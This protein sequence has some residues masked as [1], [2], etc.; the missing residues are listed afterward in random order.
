MSEFVE[1][2]AVERSGGHYDPVSEKIHYNCCLKRFYA[3]PSYIV[4]I[5]E[6]ESLKRQ[7]EQE[8]MIPGLDPKLAS[9]S[10]ITLG[11]PTNYQ[12]I[13]IIGKPAIVLAKIRELSS[14]R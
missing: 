12:K 3:N 13:D 2:T 1:L 14:G 5:E 9:F 11:A 6:N 8:D 4:C 10:T 7:I